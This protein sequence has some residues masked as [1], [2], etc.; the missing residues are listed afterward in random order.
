M[1]VVFATSKY[2]KVDDHRV[3]AGM[4]ATN[5]DQTTAASERAST[6][7]THGCTLHEQS[8]LTANEQHILDGATLNVLHGR[9]LM[10]RHVAAGGHYSH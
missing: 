6:C 4:T 8:S 7:D 9:P 1:S 3:K 2:V 10:N 5:I